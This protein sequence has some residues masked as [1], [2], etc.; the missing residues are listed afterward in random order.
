MSVCNITFSPVYFQTRV[1]LPTFRGA[2][3]SWSGHARC[4]NAPPTPRMGHTRGCPFSNAIDSLD[5]GAFD[6]CIIK[7]PFQSES[8][9]QLACP[10]PDGPRANR[11]HGDGL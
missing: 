4:G 3:C 11:G 10:T 5:S 6:P 1:S 7:A 9:N 8:E 2:R